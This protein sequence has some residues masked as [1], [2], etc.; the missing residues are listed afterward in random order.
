MEVELPL[1]SLDITS[2]STP[3]NPVVI[4]GAIPEGFALQSTP[5]GRGV[6][7]TKFFPAGSVCYVGRYILIPDVVSHFLL[8]TDQGEFAQDSE[9]HSVK[10]S[11][12][13][14]QLYLF[15][16][17][18]NHSCDPNTYNPTQTDE[19]I[20][21]CSY[22][23]VAIRDV[24]PGDQITCDYNLFEYDSH[25]KDIEHCMCGAPRCF[26]SVRGFKYLPRDVQRERI[27]FIDRDCFQRFVAGD[28]S[29]MFF[30]DLSVP[31]SVTLVPETIG[32]GFCMLS[33]RDFKAGDTI[34]TNKGLFVPVDAEVIV[35][36]QGRRRWFGVGHMVQ[37]KEGDTTKIF[38][39]FDSFQNHC[40]EPNTANEFGERDSE[41][42]SYRL[43]ALRDIAAGEELTCDYETLGGV[44]ETTIPCLCGAVNCRKVIK[45]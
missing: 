14:R 35:E 11:D 38:F 37:E 6:F 29:I 9:T 45:E 10:V 34:F 8:V 41:S 4:H 7:S 30:R 25:G 5:Y 42:V 19:E 15:D 2:Q 16:G 13:Q 23:C 24:H 36:I 32:D 20:E 21:N 40:C 31:D 3:D 12:T 17:F 44:C 26:G 22:R 33:K 43:F 39:G 1:L 18:M 28:P 27:D